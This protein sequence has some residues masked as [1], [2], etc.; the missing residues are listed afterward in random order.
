MN[1]LL[2]CNL[3]IHCIVWEITFSCLMNKKS[4]LT[5]S[6]T[7]LTLSTGN[8]FLSVNWIKIVKRISS[9]NLN[10]WLKA[11]TRL[12]I[13]LGLRWVSLSHL[14]QK[15]YTISLRIQIID[16]FSLSLIKLRIIQMRVFLWWL[17]LHL[18]L[19]NKID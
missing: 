16:N 15:W 10:R 5:G 14:V 2:L 13:R 1:L 18:L 17:K 12:H 4:L 9:L 19:I 7:A 3:R 11:S 6:K 8:H